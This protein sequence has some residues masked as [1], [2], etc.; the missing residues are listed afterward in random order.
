M[1]RRYFKV[2]CGYTYKVEE[3]FCLLMVN[4]IQ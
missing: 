3:H 1:K 2:C 4:K